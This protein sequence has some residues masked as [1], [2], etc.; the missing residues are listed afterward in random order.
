MNYTKYYTVL[1]FVM[2]NNGQQTN[3]HNEYKLS[4]IRMMDQNGHKQNEMGKQRRRK[5]KVGEMNKI[6]EI[7]M[8]FVFTC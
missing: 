7:I 5:K 3:R 2:N 8:H 1:T 6:K 4:I